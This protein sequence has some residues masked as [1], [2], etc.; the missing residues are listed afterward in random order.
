MNKRDL[1]TAIVSILKKRFP[2]LTAEEVIT[3]AFDIA[4]VVEAQI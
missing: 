1:V 4:E 2:N 3:I